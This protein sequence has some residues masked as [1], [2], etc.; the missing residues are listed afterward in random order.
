MSS[1]QNRRSVNRREVSLPATLSLEGPSNEGADGAPVVTTR[2][3]TIQNISLG[4]AQVELPERLALGQKVRLVFQIP[5]GSD[6]IDISATVRWC[7]A[8]S[9]GIQFAGLRPKEVWLLNRYFAALGI[10]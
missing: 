9:V 10:K 1:P 3:I 8:D 4:G 6:S 7:A 5:G 2:D